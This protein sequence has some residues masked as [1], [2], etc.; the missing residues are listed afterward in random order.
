MFLFHQG[1]ILKEMEFK[2]V[3]KAMESLINEL[4]EL[5]NMSK[6][7]IVAAFD[8]PPN[9]P[10]YGVK[11]S[12]NSKGMYTGDIKNIR[13][14]VEQNLMREAGSSN[15][16]NL[17]YKVVI[18]DTGEGYITEYFSQISIFL[19]GYFIP[20]R[21]WKYSDHYFLC[22]NSDFQP[23]PLKKVKNIQKI[24]DTFVI[25]KSWYSLPFKRIFGTK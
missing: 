2:N 16:N 24:D 10:S 1:V 23:Q 21:I 5:K 20:I 22:G 13:K 25:K 14:V 6:F 17:T 12:W 8:G 19:A 3:E 4:L 9:E 18:N 7:S 11:S 15:N